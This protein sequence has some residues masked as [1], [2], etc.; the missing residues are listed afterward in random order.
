M[1]SKI[2]IPIVFILFVTSL[3]TGCGPSQETLATQTA[4]MQTASATMWTPTPTVTPTSTFTPTAD[5]R[6]YE[7][8]GGIPISYVPPEG[9]SQSQPVNGSLM[10][11]YWKGE[12]MTCPLAFNM[13][14]SDLALDPFIQKSQAEV[15]KLFKDFSILS[16]TPFSTDANLEAD[17][18]EA[19]FTLAMGADIKLYMAVYYFHQDGYYVVAAYDRPF[20]LDNSQDTI[21][22][23]SMR[24]FRFDK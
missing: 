6:Y 18:M 20:D 12:T 19:S 3:L 1:K 24:T 10:G 15:A 8:A 17:K 4:K 11:W 2:I 16:Q 5:R 21:V 7:T 22:D 14:Q 13:E 23:A 9:W